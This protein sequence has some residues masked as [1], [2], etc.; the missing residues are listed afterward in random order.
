MILGIGIDLCRVGRIRRSID[1]LGPAWIDDV[2][3]AGERANCEATPDAI[4]S[5]AATFCAKEACAKALGTG[6]AQGVTWRNVEVLLAGSDS[7]VRLHE[8]AAIRLTELTPLDH[9]GRFSLT[10]HQ[11]AE[12]SLAIAVLVAYPHEAATAQ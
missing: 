8:D 12:L 5:Y 4:R 1:G 11:D 7:I 2:F 10:S 6:F 9:R 3:T